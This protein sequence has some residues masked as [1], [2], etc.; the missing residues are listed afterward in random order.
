MWNILCICWAV[1]T[2]LGTV[3]ISIPKRKD[4]KVLKK[5][6]LHEEETPKNA[7]KILILLIV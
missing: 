7:G 2:I 4:L 1:H 5:A 3:M 6:L